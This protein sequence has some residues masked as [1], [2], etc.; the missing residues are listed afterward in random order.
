[1]LLPFSTQRT[2]EVNN[3]A[4]KA[5]SESAIAAGSR[6][7]LQTLPRTSDVSTAAAS[8]VDG[9]SLAEDVPAQRGA[10]PL[11]AEGSLQATSAST[12]VGSRLA[13]LMIT[14]CHVGWVVRSMV[15]S[16]AI[17]LSIGGMRTALAASHL[18]GM[19]W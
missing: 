3:I 4:I 12:A 7:Q 13:E 5:I 17:G 10:P 1:M 6:K 19:P 2:D 18:K 14:R 11:C 9:S 16:Q 15:A 8:A